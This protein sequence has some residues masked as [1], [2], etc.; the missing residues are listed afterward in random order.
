MSSLPPLP[1]PEIFT[2]EAGLFDSLPQLIETID[3]A[4]E[5]LR[6]YKLHEKNT[7][8]VFL[9]GWAARTALSA[10]LGESLSMLITIVLV[11]VTFRLLHKQKIRARAETNKLKDKQELIQGELKQAKRDSAGADWTVVRE[12]PKISS[13]HK[14]L[15]PELYSVMDDVDGMIVPPRRSGRKKILWNPRPR[16]VK[17]D[18]RCGSVRRSNKSAAAKQ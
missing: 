2:E 13:S 4:M 11:A 16:K 9:I 6:E 3:G 8:V 14:E 1:E 18:K 15:H 12:K 10:L 17:S 7:A 5:T